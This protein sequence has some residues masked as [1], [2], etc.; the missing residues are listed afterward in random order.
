MKEFVVAFYSKIIKV[1][2]PLKLHL[3]KWWILWREKGFTRGKL[4]METTSLSAQN[5]SLI[6]NNARFPCK[7]TFSS[8]SSLL[9][10][11]SPLLQKHGS[12][13]C[14]QVWSSR[15]RSS[16]SSRCRS[17]ALTPKNT[18]P[19]R[20][21]SSMPIPIHGPMTIWTGLITARCSTRRSRWVW[22][23]RRGEWHILDKIP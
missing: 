6:N 10:A 18:A 14:R 2:Y 8:M 23:T 9:P 5:S 4:E 3:S 21:F 15:L 13:S 7:M 12:I 16:S 22:S 11:R 19:C 17:Y 1:P 20:W